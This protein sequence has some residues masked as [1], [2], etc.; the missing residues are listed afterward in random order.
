MKTLEASSM[1]IGQMAAELRA[2]GMCDSRELKLAPACTA[3]PKG[4][5]RSGRLRE[6]YRRRGG[7]TPRKPEHF[8]GQA[9]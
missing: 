3:E 5:K 7:R 1:T 6:I 4:F 9:V 2:K 8:T